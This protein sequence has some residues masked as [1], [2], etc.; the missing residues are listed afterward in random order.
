MKAR[1]LEERRI[2]E[3]EVRLALTL[4]GFPWKNAKFSA[5]GHAMVLGN[6]ILHV[7]HL[8]T[9]MGKPKPQS[10]KADDGTYSNPL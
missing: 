9:P 1:E 10:A 2:A 4:L 5:S 6:K 8:S 7:D 3:E